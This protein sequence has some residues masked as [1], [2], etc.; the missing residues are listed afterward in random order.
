MSQRGIEWRLIRL[1]LS[2]GGDVNA[3]PLRLRNILE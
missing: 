1:E 2:T 3:I